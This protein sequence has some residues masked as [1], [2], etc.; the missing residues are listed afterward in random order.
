MRSTFQVYETE[1]N[2]DLRITINGINKDVSLDE[3]LKKVSEIYKSAN[4]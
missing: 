1:G 4:L 2:K 3:V